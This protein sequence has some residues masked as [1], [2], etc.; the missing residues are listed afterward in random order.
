M[1]AI[2]G[3]FLLSGASR[4]TKGSKYYVVE[5]APDYHSFHEISPLHNPSASL[6]DLSTPQNHSATLH[7]F[8]PVE[9]TV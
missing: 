9:M 5:I 2:A 7:D 4:R 1:P 3:I 6:R 8:I